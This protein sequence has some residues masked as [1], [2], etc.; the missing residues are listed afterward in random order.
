MVKVNLLGSEPEEEP[1]PE[2]TEPA[3]EEVEEVAEERAELVSEPDEGE[4]MT[5]EL[6]SSLEEEILGRKRSGALPYLL[7]GLLVVLIG[8]LLWKVWPSGKKEAKA[9]KPG[10]T[11]VATTA[12]P[13][14]GEATAP[15]AKAEAGRPA[16]ATAPTA[17]EAGAPSATAAAPAAPASSA[18]IS[19]ILAPTVSSVANV[20]RVLGTSVQGASLGLVSQADGQMVVEL[21]GKSDAQL[22]AAQQ[23][24]LAAFGG[25]SLKLVTTDTKTVE[26]QTYRRRIFTVE[27][28]ASAQ[29]SGGRIRYLEKSELDKQLRQMVRASGLALRSLEY[30]KPVEE[31]QFVKTPVRLKAL[32]RREAISKFLRDLADARLNVRITKI[33]L[34]PADWQ[35]TVR[36]R[37]MTLVVEMDL[38]QPL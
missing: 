17:T 36:D 31:E 22:K 1:R 16:E 11:T 26:G 18:A 35:S 34:V 9:P 19:A 10:E 25:A 15:A 23:A 37:L 21:L 8:V 14:A 2:V 7:V 38:C 4:S 30:A 29:V 3:K 6:E 5:A 33:L 27:V 20:G 32:G 12:Q 13:G 24:Y 28:P